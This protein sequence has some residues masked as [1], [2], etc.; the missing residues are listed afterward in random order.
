VL[1]FP[2]ISFILSSP[3]IMSTKRP[4]ID[5]SKQVQSSFRTKNIF[6]AENAM[7]KHSIICN[8]HVISGRYVLLADFDHLNLTP[9]L[10]TSSLYHFVTIK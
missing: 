5:K 6:V 10:K 4:R 9:I 2:V 8:K 1:L 7:F 3:L